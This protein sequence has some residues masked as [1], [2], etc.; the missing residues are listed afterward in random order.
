M[1]YIKPLIKF[2][3]ESNILNKEEYLFNEK[4]KLLNKEFDEFLNEN[5]LEIN[6]SNI[7]LTKDQQ[8]IN[9]RPVSCRHMFD[10]MPVGA[11]QQ[12]LKQPVSLDHGR[13]TKFTV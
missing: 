1:K 3:N 4:I 13:K 7:Q 9:N 11:A 5:I 2:I 6:E 12:V 8:F 10:T